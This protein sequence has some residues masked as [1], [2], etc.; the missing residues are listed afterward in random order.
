MPPFLGLACTRS[1]RLVHTLFRIY[2]E[3]QSHR[4]VIAVR[5]LHNHIRDLA[6][7]TFR[8]S[9]EASQQLEHRTDGGLIVRQQIR[10]ILPGAPRPI[11]P[12]TAR[13]QRADLDS[14]RRDLHRQS[15]AETTHGPLGRVIWRISAVR[16]AATHRRHL[17]YVTALL[18]AH[19]RYGGARC[20]NHA[21]EARVPNRLEVIRAHLLE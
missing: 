8:T 5:Q 14:E 18:L 9:F 21:V 11:G 1:F 17:K 13:L 4:H 12:N 3:D 20:V 15:V 10:R 19:Y 7:I 16:D 2:T 6:R